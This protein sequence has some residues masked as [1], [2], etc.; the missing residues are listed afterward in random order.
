MGEMKGGYNIPYNPVPVLLRLDKDLDAQ[1]ELW[2][3]LHHQGDVGWASYA[4][5]PQMARI[6]KALPS[7]DWNPYALACTIE[8]ERHR[9][10]NPKF[11]F[12]SND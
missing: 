6:C 9:K 3:N 2:D 4:A 5:V 10:T 1:S 7:R 11:G 8:I 12:Y